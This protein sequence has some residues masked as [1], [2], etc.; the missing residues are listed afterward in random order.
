MG[1]YKL[2]SDAE[3][4]P[5]LFPYSHVLEVHSLGVSTQVKTDLNQTWPTLM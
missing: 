4:V 5:E 1:E 2:F 3:L